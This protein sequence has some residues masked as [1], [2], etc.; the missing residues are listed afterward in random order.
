MNEQAFIQKVAQRIGP[1]NALQQ[2]NPIQVAALINLLKEKGIFT[3]SELEAKTHEEF[4]KAAD[5]LMKMPIPSPLH[6]T[7]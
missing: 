1:V 2:L 3:Q 7:R 5:M 6:V 4:A